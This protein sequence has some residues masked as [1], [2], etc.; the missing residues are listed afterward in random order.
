[1]M[2]SSSSAFSDAAS[3]DAFYLHRWLTLK[4]VPGVFRNQHF[5]ANQRRI[6]DGRL[7]ICAQFNEHHLGTKRP[8]GHTAR[9]TQVHKP[10]DPAP[11]NFTKAN[12]KEVLFSFKSE[13]TVQM[14]AAELD[15]IPVDESAHLVFVNP[16]PLLLGHGLLVP[17]VRK[18][19]PQVLTH[20]SISVA[21]QFLVCAHSNTSDLPQPIHRSLN[22]GSTESSVS[23][24][25][26]SQQTH[27]GGVKI[28]FNSLGGW[29]SVN[30]CH[31]HTFFVDDVWHNGRFP[32]ESA[33][34]QLLHTGSLTSLFLIDFPLP[35]LAIGLS[36]DSECSP[37][38]LQ[39]LSLVV[40]RVTDHLIASNIPHQLVIVNDAF[41]ESSFASAS[42]SSHSSLS[43]SCRVRPLVLL[44]P[45]QFQTTGALDGQ[46]AVALAE[47]CGLAVL[48]STDQSAAFTESEY[49]QLMAE[50]RL[51]DDQ[52]TQ[53]VRVATLSVIDKI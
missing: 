39:H 1:M 15:S 50:A 27:A 24:I 14:V 36:A 43:S 22:H 34:R 19:Q 10:F 4:E 8:A 35:T 17:H 52:W 31:F 37:D 26:L 30:H 48:Y 33:P 11:F 6:L 23:S 42:S 25:E 16:N 46:M 49:S 44:A 29:S 32:I 3:F 18:C 5:E 9:P 7:G 20:E 12:P 47:I 51:N 21:L 45:R 38:S 40:S 2:A 41:S 53:L 13:P 28:G